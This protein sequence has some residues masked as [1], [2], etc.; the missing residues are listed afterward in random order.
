MYTRTYFPEDEKINIPEKY[1][2]NA[3]SDAPETEP[4]EQVEKSEEVMGRAR[5]DD[6]GIFGFLSRLGGGIFPVFGKIGSDFHLG[7]EELLIIG[8]ALFLFLSKGGDKECAIMLIILLI[9]Q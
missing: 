6:G 9:F 8:I 4:T 2:V 7:R 3:F 1:N 5:E